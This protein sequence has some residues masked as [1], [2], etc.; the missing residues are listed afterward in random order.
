MFLLGSAVPPD[1]SICKATQRNNLHVDAA[2][3]SARAAAGNAQLAPPLEE[4]E[5]QQGEEAMENEVQE[6][7]RLSAERMLG[8]P[9]KDNAL[10]HAPGYV[11][12][13]MEDSASRHAYGER[14]NPH[15]HV[16]PP[17]GNAAPTLLDAAAPSAR[18][19][20]LWYVRLGT[21]FE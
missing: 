15:Y 18:A 9:H 19:R 14:V 17:V 4:W 11:Q 2:E 21:P 10:S 13:S 1:R 3:S 20:A 12:H 5:E 8:R 6:E 7:E 16:A